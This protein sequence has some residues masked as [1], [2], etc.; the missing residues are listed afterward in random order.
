[1]PST[2]MHD[3]GFGGGDPMPPQFT[4]FIVVIWILS[5]I[6]LIFFACYYELL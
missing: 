6:G 4:V 3:G 1:M 5:I 2:S